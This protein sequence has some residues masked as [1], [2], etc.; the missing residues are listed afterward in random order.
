MSYSWRFNAR[1]GA[2]AEFQARQTQ[3]NRDSLTSKLREYFDRHLNDPH[4]LNLQHEIAVA[5]ALVHEGLEAMS[6]GESGENWRACQVVCHDLLTAVQAA[7]TA[8]IESSVKKLGKAIEGRRGPPNGRH[9]EGVTNPVVSSV[10]RLSRAAWWASRSPSLRTQRTLDAYRSGLELVLRHA[11][12][13]MLIDLYFDP[14]ERRYRDAVT[15]LTDAGG[16]TPAPLVEIHRVAWYD[17]SGDKR[18]QSV[19]V[20]D[21]L[22]PRLAAATA[23]SGLAFE[24]YLWDDFHDRYLISDLVGISLPYGFDTTADPNART[25]CAA[26]VRPRVESAHSAT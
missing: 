6:R 12:S 17:D 7:D 1:R 3:Q 4:L 22:R 23:Q 16:R 20:E 26:R 18:P 13:I 14:V 19:R 25:I 5:V 15:L 11:N 10:G 21:A 8:A 9:Q 2:L 24:V